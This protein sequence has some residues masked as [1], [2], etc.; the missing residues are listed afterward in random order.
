MPENVTAWRVRLPRTETYWLA[1]EGNPLRDGKYWL[2]GSITRDG[3]GTL[4]LDADAVAALSQDSLCDRDGHVTWEGGIPV[5]HVGRDT[6]VLEPGV[7]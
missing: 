3:N 4:L 7:S 5:L 6:Y 1:G 2:P